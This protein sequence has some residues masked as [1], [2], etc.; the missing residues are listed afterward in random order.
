MENLDDSRGK[1][2][3]INKLGN[4][5]TDY[6]LPSQSIIHNILEFQTGEE[7]IGA[8][9]LLLLELQNIIDDTIIIIIIIIII[10]LV[11]H[12]YRNKYDTNGTITMLSMRV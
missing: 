12:N 8:H 10:I 5:V 3:P 4:S 6:R 9:M 7:I 1:F 11:Q 2:P